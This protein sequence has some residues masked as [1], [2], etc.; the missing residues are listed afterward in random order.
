MSNVCF[1]KK[2]IL[3]IL[4]WE[5]S[6]PFPWNCVLIWLPSAL[7]TLPW[8]TP[9]CCSTAQTPS[10]RWP[11]CPPTPSPTWWIERAC[12]WGWRMWRSRAPQSGSYQGYIF[13]SL[14]PHPLLRKREEKKRERGRKR[15]FRP[16]WLQKLGRIFKVQRGGGKI[17]LGCHNIYPC[18]IWN[19][20][21]MTD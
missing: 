2:F 15:E 1:K 16:L 3:N 6:S 11:G 14:P 4:T 21:K 8:A 5:N 18:Y 9:A 12:C 19:G 17:F 7:V 13:C 20:M 10:R